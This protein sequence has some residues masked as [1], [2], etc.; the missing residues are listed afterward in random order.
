[1]AELLSLD[2][3]TK[4]FGGVT[5]VKG[6][7]LSVDE[8]EI[9]GLIGPNGAGK[10]TV[11]NLIAGIYKPSTGKVIF[12]GKLINGK[13]PSEI[14]KLGIARTFQTVRPFPKM[15]AID[16]VIVGD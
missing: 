3:V 15:T 11:F 9:V 10:T 1:M 7:S 8:G 4:S 12:Q 14:C 2:G 16:N 5:A 13:D 6:L